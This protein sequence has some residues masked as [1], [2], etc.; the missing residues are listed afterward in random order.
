MGSDLD[1][2]RPGVDQEVGLEEHHHHH[3][4]SSINEGSEM[5]ILWKKNEA[6]IHTRDAN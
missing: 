1:S 6:Y 2:D 4:S 5:S 3:V